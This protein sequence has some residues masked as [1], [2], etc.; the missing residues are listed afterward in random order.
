MVSNIICTCYQYSVTFAGASD[1]PLLFYHLPVPFCQAR[2]VAVRKDVSSK[3]GL[4]GNVIDR[5]EETSTPT[6]SHDPYLT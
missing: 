2:F 1:L 5:S 4:Y 3:Q 6:A